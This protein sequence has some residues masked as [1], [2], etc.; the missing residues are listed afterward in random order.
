MFL[1]QLNRLVFFSYYS[2]EGLFTKQLSNCLAVHKK[3]Q[4]DSNAFL[5]GRELISSRNFRF[6]WPI[7]AKFGTE[8]L[9]ATRLIVVGFV[10][11]DIFKGIFCLL[12]STTFSVFWTFPTWFASNSFDNS[13]MGVSVSFVKLGQLITILN[14]LVSMNLCSDFPHFLL[15]FGRNFVKDVWT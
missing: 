12:A 8:S 10:S 15:Q 7:R 3:W 6:S 5:K 1:F 13:L 11:T 4:N 9:R 14:L 2:V